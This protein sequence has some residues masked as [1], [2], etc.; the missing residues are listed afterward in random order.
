MI[1]EVS[2]VSTLNLKTDVNGTCTL[3]YS[4]AR[5]ANIK[6]YHNLLGYTCMLRSHHVCVCVCVC[7]CVYTYQQ[8][9]R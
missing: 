3:Q 6:R 1:G 5:M 7:V 4:Y 8:S 9:Q 2:F